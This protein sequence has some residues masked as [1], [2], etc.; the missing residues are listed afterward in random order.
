MHD[1]DSPLSYQMWLNRQFNG[2]KLNYEVFPIN[3][4][5]A[6]GVGSLTKFTPEM[7]SH[8]PEVETVIQ[9]TKLVLQPDPSQE[10]RCSMLLLN[11]MLY[12]EVIMVDCKAKLAVN[13]VLCKQFK[14]TH[15]D[16]PPLGII[17]AGDSI[18]VSDLCYTAFYKKKGLSPMCQ[19]ST[20][21]DFDVTNPTVFRDILE[22]MTI[23][24][25]SNITYIT[26]PK[27]V[28]RDICTVITVAYSR[29]YLLELLTL[30]E[31]EIPCEEATGIY[32]CV[33]PIGSRELTDKLTSLSN[34]FLCD[35]GTYISGTFLCNDIID[36]A[37]ATD[38]YCCSATDRIGANNITKSCQYRY[39]AR[40]FSNSAC[41]LWLYKIGLFRTY[42]KESNTV[43]KYL[44]KNYRIIRNTYEVLYLNDIKV[45]NKTEHFVCNNNSTNPTEF[46]DDTVPDCL[47]GEDE[48]QYKGLQVGNG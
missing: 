21:W 20:F 17:C 32:H 44:G 5:L 22:S 24:Q 41:V 9:G 2:I 13:R 8:I 3:E 39:E 38:E 6:P 26:L 27:G 14:R 29:L 19:K 37:N 40:G 30:S 45:D 15:S 34:V 36:C 16:S 11:N 4:N 33:I 7:E 43:K 25:R 1:N 47:E 42:T 46:L 35:D 18:Q 12:P 23:I 28:E 48:P 10:K 31:D